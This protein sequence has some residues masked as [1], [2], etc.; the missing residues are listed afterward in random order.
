MDPQG[1]SD[2]EVVAKVLS[3]DFR[4]INLPGRKIRFKVESRRR[5]RPVTAPARWEYFWERTLDPE[6]IPNERAPS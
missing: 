3:P 5:L 6:I 1:S 4:H 2:E